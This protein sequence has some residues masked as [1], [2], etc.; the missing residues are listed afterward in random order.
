MSGEEPTGTA[1]ANDESHV[2]R[3]LTLPCVMMASVVF[4]LLQVD[5]T[6]FKSSAGPVVFHTRMRF[7][8][9]KS[10]EP[11]PPIS[12]G[13]D[14]SI[15]ATVSHDFRESDGYVDLTATSPR[16]LRTTL[17]LPRR[18]K[19]GMALYATRRCM[20]RDSGTESSAECLNLSAALLVIILCRPMATWTLAILTHV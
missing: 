18:G 13:A 2:V 10:D 17:F 19:P 20:I 16:K 3:R 1:R 15:R 14:T 6:R 7:M 8:R 11:L 4:P 5:R 9:W 12:S